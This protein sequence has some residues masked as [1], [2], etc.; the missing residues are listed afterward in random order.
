M[1]KY[2]L[3]EYEPEKEQ[4]VKVKVSNEKYSSKVRLLKRKTVEKKS[5]NY[6]ILG[7]LKNRNKVKEIKDFMDVIEIDSHDYP[8]LSKKATNYK[9]VG[10]IKVGENDFIAVTKS[11]IL[12][13]THGQ[14]RGVA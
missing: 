12:T 10:Y 14:A 2:I 6:H 4:K 5:D 11:R 13:N 9:I 7:Y 3:E 1:S 8:L